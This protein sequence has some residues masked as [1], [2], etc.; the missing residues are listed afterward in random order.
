MPSYA[1]D[2][3]VPVARSRAQIESLLRDWDCDG[4]QWTDLF[5]E[6]RC[7]L[8][9]IWNHDGNR[10]CARFAINLEDPKYEL[11]EKQQGQRTRSCFRILYNWIRAA[12]NAVDAGIVPAEAIFMPFLEDANGQTV[13]EVIGPRIPELLVGSAERFALPAGD[14][15]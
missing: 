9:F 11:T 1:K 15:R 14:K 5:K 10:Y 6:H 8:R 12:L 7:E 3:G 4:I 13:A 2:T